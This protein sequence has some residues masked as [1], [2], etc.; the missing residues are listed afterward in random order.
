MWKHRKLLAE[1]SV[2]SRSIGHITLFRELLVKPMSCT[3]LLGVNA[4]VERVQQSAVTD[5]SFDKVL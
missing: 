4:G 3:S 2:E 5:A 1:R